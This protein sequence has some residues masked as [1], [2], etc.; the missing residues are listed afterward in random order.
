MTARGALLLAAICACVLPSCGD[1]APDPA[2]TPSLLDR[3]IVAAGGEANL[4]SI[5]SM[6]SRSRGEQWGGRSYQAVIQRLL[7]DRYRHDMDVSDASLV[8]ATDGVDIWATLDDYPI[9]VTPADAESLRLSLRL[10]QI[11]MLLPLKSVPDLKLKDEGTEDGNHVLR[12]TFPKHGKLPGPDGGSDPATTPRGPYRLFFDPAT[13]LLR[14]IEFEAEIFGED[15]PRQTRIE[16]LDY[17]RVDGLMVPFAE[18]MTVEGEPR[19]EERVEQ[20]LIN[21]TIPPERFKR[22]APPA[23][24]AIRTR[25]SPEVTV[26][27][28]EQ[29]GTRPE[30]ALD[31]EETLGRYLEKHGLRRNGPPFRLQPLA[32]GELPAVGAP[33]GPLPPETRP[34]SRPATRELP[35]I[36]VFPARTIYTAV[37][38]GAD[39]AARSG[40]IERILSRVRA[41]GREPDGPCKIV[42]WSPD[43]VQLQIPVRAKKG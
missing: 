25:S 27:I 28:L 6:E 31:A 33:I 5:R 9:P 42:L 24:L 18:R 38:P 26:A 14:Q 35:R 32:E 22:P 30:A 41:D 7:P 10:S 1:G 11:S 39:P 19:L 29:Q 37:V 36:A 4:A 2:S 12:I 23:D 34:T 3:A 40:A 20:I 8:Q 21:P 43:I 15:G 16:L 17:R 13:S